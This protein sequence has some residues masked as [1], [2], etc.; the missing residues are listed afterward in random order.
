MGMVID[1][2]RLFDNL[3]IKVS[4]FKNLSYFFQRNLKM[5]LYVALLLCFIIFYFYDEVDKFLKG[6]TTFTQTFAKV[7]SLPL[8]SIIICM[9]G[10]KSY[11]KHTFGYHSTIDMVYDKDETYKKFNLTPYEMIDDLA[12]VLSKD[13]ELSFGVYLGN[14]YPLTT[15]LNKVNDREILV[16]TLWTITGVCYLIE[17]LFTLG[18]HE[19]PWFVMNAKPKENYW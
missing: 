7:E 2:V 18:T 13:F 6:S 15:G 5:V 9:P 1:L 16:K 19:S 12:F 14:S 8:P 17:P 3:V 11:A 10:A 4:F